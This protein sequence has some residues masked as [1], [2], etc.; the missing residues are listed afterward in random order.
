VVSEIELTNN[1]V[2][3]LNTGTIQFLDQDGEPLRVNILFAEGDQE[4]ESRWWSQMN[5]MIEPLGRVKVAT[6][7]KD[8][9]VIGAVRVTSRFPVYG[10]PCLRLESRLW[11]PARPSMKR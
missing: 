8:D 1:A 7:G 6:L 9:L 5:F 4:P 3:G 10:L 2:L 11:A